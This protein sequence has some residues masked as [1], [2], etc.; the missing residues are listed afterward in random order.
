MRKKYFWKIYRTT[1]MVPTDTVSI[2]ALQQQTF[3]HD[4]FTEYAF[5]PKNTG[6][7]FPNCSML[8]YTANI[9]RKH[10]DH[11][12]NPRSSALKKT[13]RS[14]LQVD[15]VNTA[16]CYSSFYKRHSCPYPRHQGIWASDI[17]APTFSTS[18]LDG[19]EWSASRLS[20]YTPGER[21][22]NTHRI[23]DRGWT[24]VPVWKLRKEKDLLPL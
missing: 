23:R 16:C 4:S 19:G 1:S 3:S 5:R 8:L 15:N 20:Y 12:T 10:R 21:G 24:S 9:L 13:E 11:N 2:S 6:K 14:M 17:I 22:T 7:S 18:A